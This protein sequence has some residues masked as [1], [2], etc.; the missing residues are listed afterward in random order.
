MYTHGL[1]SHRARVP[2]MCTQQRETAQTRQRELFSASC[3]LECICMDILGPLAKT[4]SGNQYE[5]IMT[6][7]YSKLTR[8][9]LPHIQ[10]T[11][12]FPPSCMSTGP[13]HTGYT[14]S[15]EQTMAHSSKESSLRPLVNS[16][17]W[18]ASKEQNISARQIGQLNNHKNPDC[19]TKL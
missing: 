2:L 14:P 6:Y 18:W 9:L 16:L 7:I 8:E 3:P 15:C 17:S 11:S 13:Y 4:T 19:R 10:A 12:M 1:C 5:V